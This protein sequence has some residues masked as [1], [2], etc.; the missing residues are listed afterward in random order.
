MSSF[1]KLDAALLEQI[2][3]IT[4]IDNKNY[5]SIFQLGLNILEGNEFSAKEEAQKLN[6]SGSNLSKICTSVATL[7]W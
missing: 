6:I 3:L 1:F 5:D 4:E 7:I 2:G